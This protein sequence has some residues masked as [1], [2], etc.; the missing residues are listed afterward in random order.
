MLAGMR[1]IRS[2]FAQLE[3]VSLQLLADYMPVRNGR[4][5]DHASDF[6]QDAVRA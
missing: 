1:C 3:A 5:V 6:A 4:D 2:F